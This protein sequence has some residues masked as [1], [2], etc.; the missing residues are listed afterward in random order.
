MYWIRN[1]YCFLSLSSSVSVTCVIR[2]LRCS[3]TD[4]PGAA[5]GV[6]AVFLDGDCRHDEDGDVGDH[7]A[8]EA[9]KIGVGLTF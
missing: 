9:G 3:T 8:V 5:E 7:L 1:V 6:L 2:K 4:F